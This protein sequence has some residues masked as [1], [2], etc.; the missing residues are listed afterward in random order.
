M[1]NLHEIPAKTMPHMLYI[2]S[3]WWFQ[4]KNYFII[5]IHSPI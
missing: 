5:M 2:F 1:R 3:D 4:K